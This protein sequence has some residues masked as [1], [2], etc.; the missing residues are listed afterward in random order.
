MK[1]NKSNS[2]FR[3]KLKSVDFFPKSLPQT[4]GTTQFGGAI[5]A[6][7]V[8]L[9][10]FLLVMEYSE[11]TTPVLL[12]HVDLVRQSEEEEDV[13]I[14]FDI[15]FFALKCDDVAVS[16]ATLTS[17][18][19]TDYKI[20]ADK[21]PIESEGCR[22]KGVVNQIDK[23]AGDLHVALKMH[24]IEN[25]QVGFSLDEFMKYNSSHEIHYFKILGGGKPQQEEKSVKNNEDDSFELYDHF[26]NRK[27]IV[28]LPSY[29]IYDLQIV[30]SLQEETTAAKALKAT[31]Y[32]FHARE[33]VVSVGTLEDS[34]FAL[35]KLGLPGVYFTYK[36]SPLKVNKFYAKKYFFSRFVIRCLGIVGGVAAVSA[37]I[38][39]FLHDNIDSWKQKLD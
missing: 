24:A 11:Y 6:V 14:H 12:E 18:V 10:F 15:S 38:D 23:H 34:I 32:P 2:K 33:H 37:L 39:S 28:N 25:G 29:H 30:P 36:F 13:N 8:A 31:S 26:K 3:N 20:Q 1:E 5:S 9:I 16:L 27:N 21:S 35:Q 4:T 19:N 22:L 7:T 17:Q